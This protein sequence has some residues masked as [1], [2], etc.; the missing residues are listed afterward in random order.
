MWRLLDSRVE[1]LLKDGDVAPR[2]QLPGMDAIHDGRVTVYLDCR[3]H[4]LTR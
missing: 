1:L 2:M 3:G 4:R